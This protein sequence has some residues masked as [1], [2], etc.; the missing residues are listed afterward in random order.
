MEN[1]CAYQGRGI[2]RDKKSAAIHE[3]C[4]AYGSY[5]ESSACLTHGFNEAEA[6]EKNVVKKYV[7]IDCIGGFNNV[8]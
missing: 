3:V 2:Y 5:D 1:D 4:D 8:N 6:N 7:G